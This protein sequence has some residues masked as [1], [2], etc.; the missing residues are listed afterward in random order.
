M[1][2]PILHAK[3]L[4]KTFYSPSPHTILNG[5]NLTAHKGE[6]IAIGGRSG[7]GKSTLLQ[8]LGTLD[9]PTSGQLEILGTPTSHFNCSSLRCKHLGFVFQSYYLLAD[10]STLENVLMAARIARQPTHP[11]S[12]AYTRA[13][14]LLHD[15][16]LSH[17]IHHNTKLL[18]GG[19]KQRTAIARALCNDP[20]IILADEPTGNLDK[21]TAEDIYSILLNT[22][23]TLIVVTHD[24][25]LIQ[26]CSSSY[27]LSNGELTPT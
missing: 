12:P 14:Q 22:K 11:N 20:D 5:I 26:K 6:S 27:T 3:K 21:H 15:V 25:L 2:T 24:P 23:K 13:I 19:E 16:G 9:S 17:R 18:S 8:L 10:F 4:V 7:Q 1:T